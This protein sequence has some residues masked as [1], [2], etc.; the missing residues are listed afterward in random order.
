MRAMVGDRKATGDW[1]QKKR[2]VSDGRPPLVTRD[3]LIDAVVRTIID[4]IVAG[5]LKDGDVLPSQDELAR[6]LEVSRASLR[7][8]LNRLSV[9]G[10]IETRHGAGT[11]VKMVR[12]VEYMNSLSSLVIVEQTS[13]REL[14]DVRLCIESALASLAARNATDDNVVELRSAVGRMEDA[15]EADD[16]K[17]FVVGDFQFHMCVARSSNNRVLGKVLEIVS[18][19]LY[20]FILQIVLKHPSHTL[21]AASHH[22]Q[23]YLAI[24]DQDPI[25]A[26]QSM[27]RHIM[28]LMR[29][30]DASL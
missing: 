1:R 24:R 20:E 9:M 30:A 4:K 13:A 28:D 21:T 11:F 10:L 12:P 8:A 14:L 7:E 18:D 27:E 17:G 15:I 5:E 2:G 22:R 26:G 25:V 16:L 6:S 19:L 23:I 29:L 3:S